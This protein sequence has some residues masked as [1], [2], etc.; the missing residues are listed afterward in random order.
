MSRPRRSLALKSLHAPAV[1]ARGYLDEMIIHGGEYR[2]RGRLLSEF[3]SRG[4]SERLAGLTMF[5]SRTIG[6][7]ELEVLGTRVELLDAFD[8]HRAALGLTP[9]D[10]LI[11]PCPDGV[12]ISRSCELESVVLV[13]TSPAHSDVRRALA[14]GMQA[15][16]AIARARAPQQRLFE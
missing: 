12:A 8:A 15:L 5:A 9:D 13:A 11:L 14:V 16:D 10:A 6:A 4:I 7:S 1:G 2:R 3:R